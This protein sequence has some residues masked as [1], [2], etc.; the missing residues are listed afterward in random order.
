M[1][2]TNDDG[3]DA[4]GLATLVDAVRDAPWINQWVVV[5]PAEV[6]SA[7]SHSITLHRPVHVEERAMP[8][9][10]GWAAEGRPADC[11]K[12]GLS[13]VLPG[14]DGGFDLVLSGINAGANVG[15][16][17]LYSGTVGAAREASFAGVP[18]IA[19]S[20][21]L[22]D[23]DAVD[24]PRCGELVRDAVDELVKGPL[25]GDTLLNVNIPWLD[26]GRE[27]RPLVAVP[28]SGSSLVIDYAL[29]PE[30]AAGRGGFKV[31][32]A[33]QFVAEEPGTDVGCLFEG[34]VT[35]SPLHYDLTCRPSVEAWA[36]ALDGPDVSA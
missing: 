5:A 32:N 6:Q 30:S 1:L 19:L 15:I 25:A 21:H 11:V 22:K 4:P 20:L 27:T 33:M 28:V 35:V 7:M 34:H 3:I 8:W 12:L 10:K 26:H 16:N 31:K 24:W 2:I 13:G 29:E 14:V 9:G 23:W 18:A 36:A 17:V